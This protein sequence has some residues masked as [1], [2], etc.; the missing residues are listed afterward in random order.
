MHVEADADQVH[1]PEDRRLRDPERPPHDCVRF[2]D[3]QSSINGLRDRAREPEAPQAI[4]DEG[5][6]V[7]A[8]HDGLAESHVGE[9]GEGL[10]RVGPRVGAARELEQPHRPGRVEEV[11]DSEVGDERLGCADEELRDR[12]RRRVRSHDGGRLPRG[13]EPP[14]EVALDVD[15]LDDRLD[16]PVGV[17]DELEA[18][19]VEA[20]RVDQPR[21]ALGDERRRTLLR[22]PLHC[23]VREVAQVD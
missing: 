5:R 21:G 9:P 7:L 6:C 12:D 15:I 10:D 8:A 11:R 23:R 1:E 14:V 19:V 16:D 3:A 13:V 22:H 20:A 2:L 18:A 4:G 17:A